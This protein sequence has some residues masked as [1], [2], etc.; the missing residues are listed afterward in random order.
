MPATISQSPIPVPTSDNL[1]QVVTAIRNAL[2]S[3]TNTDAG[4]AGS[5]GSLHSGTTNVSTFTVTQ[6]IIV[7]VT[8]P[9]S[10]VISGG[11]GTFSGT[12]TVNELVSLTLLNPTTGQTWIWQAP[13]SLTRGG[14]VGQALS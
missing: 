6:Q 5:A 4:R 1:L 13:T 7:P 2:I 14:T 3:Q 9:L 8:Y 10:G 11:T 12:V